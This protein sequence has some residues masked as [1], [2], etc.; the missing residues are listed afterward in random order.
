M[1]IRIK[2]KLF[3]SHFLA[4]ILV[5]GSIGS[6][7]YQS[8][9][10]NLKESLRSRLMYSA[11]LLSNNFNSEELEL[12]QTASDT[13]R[14]EYHKNIQ[15]LRQLTASNP[16]IA[17]IYVMRLDDGVPKFVIDSDPE[18]P[19]APGEIYN[20]TIPE[21]MEGFQSVSVDK[22]ITVD[23]WGS[24]LSGYAPIRS[25]TN[26]Y[27]IGI[28]MRADEVQAKL[29]DLK[30][31]AVLSLIVSFIFAY[32]FSMFLSKNLVKRMDVLYRRCIE[33]GA[34]KENI[35]M[36]KGD[37]LDQLSNTFEYMIEHMQHTQSDLETLVESRTW[38]L[39]NA[40]QE[41]E[42]EISE[43]K[44]AEA[45]LKIAART[46]YLTGLI[47][48]REMVEMLHRAV[49]DYSRFQRHFSVVLVDMDNFKNINDSFGHDVGDEVL[50][51]I[52]EKMQS[53]LRTQDTIARWGGEEL[54][55]LMPDFKREE[56]MQQAERIRV[57][58]ELSTFQ[59]RQFALQ[60]TASFGVAEFDAAQEIDATLK[61]ADIALY[62]GKE[63]GRNCVASE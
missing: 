24:F 44:K 60:V 33:E 21:L 18:K 13:E 9:I 59:A 10:D 6:Y 49:D 22:Q 3:I 19:A 25:R 39:Q 48:R 43:R 8:A 15:Y 34:L 2:T 12:L 1:T 29:A 20:Q 47:N 28:D 45:A 31:K 11:A 4:I 53:L 36:E 30:Q 58:L 56:A 63:K 41:L 23:K 62:K 54:L 61:R 42:L 32:V 7:F 17:F 51:A 5:S 26:P 57:H 55:I 52:A 40:N 50:K 37:E 16:D 35:K 38:A 27:L 14:P 46:D